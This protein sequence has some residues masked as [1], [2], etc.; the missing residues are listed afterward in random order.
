M[1]ESL[2]FLG[3]LFHIKVILLKYKSRKEDVQQA[4]NFKCSPDEARRVLPFSKKNS[5]LIHE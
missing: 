4:F 2:I 1:S 5:N 3:K